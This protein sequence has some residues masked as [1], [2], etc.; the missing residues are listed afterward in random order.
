[1]S[2][3]DEEKSEADSVELDVLMKEYDIVS[4]EIRQRLATNERVMG[5]GLT[6]IVVGLT[7]AIKDNVKEILL[8]MPIGF[9]AVL[10]YALQNNTALVSLGGYRCH[11]QEQINARVGKKILTW[12]TIAPKLVHKNATVAA[13]YAIYGLILSFS[14]AVS[15]RTAWN[16]YP[17]YVFIVNLILIA[18]VTALLVFSLTR[19]F[20]IFRRTQATVWNETPQITTTDGTIGGRS[21]SKRNRS[22][23]S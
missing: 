23:L 5:L 22:K 15:F 9:F 8:F 11:L 1:M 17:P 19:W 12:E 4:G 14:I 3:H 6:I 2:R 13:L 20:T 16:S 18:I 10:F 21:A 7:F